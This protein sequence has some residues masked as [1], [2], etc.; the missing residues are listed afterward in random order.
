MNIQELKTDLIEIGLG[1]NL[2]LAL[3]L[4]LAGSVRKTPWKMSV[5]V[6]GPSGI[7][8]SSLVKLIM[9]LIPEEDILTVSRMTPAALLQRGDLSSKILAICERFKDATFEQSIRQLISEGEVAYFN[10]NGLQY[11][12]GPTTLIET[13]VSPDA[14][15]TENKSR[16]FVV[17]ANTSE[18]AKANIQ[19]RQ[20]LL[21][22]A[23]GLRMNSSFEKIKQKHQEF[24]KSLDPSIDVRIPFAEKITFQTFAQHATRINERILNVITAIA[25]IN[26]RSREVVEIEGKRC[27]EA[28]KDDFETAATT[29]QNLSIDEEES[30]L[31]QGTI[32]FL[33]ILKKHSELLCQK[34]AFMRNGIHEIIVASDYPNKSSNAINKQLSILKR[35]GII[36]ESV[37]RGAKNSISYSLNM[38]LLSTATDKLTKNCYAS[39][40]LA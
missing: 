12:K 15:C 21:R 26:Q 37:V 7:G 36:D 35:I 31:S 9:K 13:T 30:A 10:A 33:E 8:K 3:L 34:G 29:L 17:G 20:K 14:I 32:W 11:L 24:Q 39:L 1:D 23:E 5:L 2:Y 19:K 16:Y 28:T 40:R 38:E 18:K 25:F 27:I 4:Y 22:T 6:T